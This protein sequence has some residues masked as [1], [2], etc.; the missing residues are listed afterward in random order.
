VSPFVSRHLEGKSVV[1]TGGGRG[2]GRAI[3]LGAADA[4]ARVVVADYGGAVDRNQSG[5]SEAADA[6]VAEI[7]AAGGEAVAS[8]ADVSTMD[9]GRE[10]VELA[11]DTFG[12][13]DAMVCSAGITVLKYLWDIEEQE[14][15]D[16]IAVH[17]KGHFSCAK[18]AA[19][20]MVP[21]R[22]GSLVFLSSGALNGMPNVTAY[23]TAKAGILGFTWS[24]ANALG[25]FGITTNCMVPSAATRMSDNI[26]GN[27]GKLTERFGD[28]MRSDLAGGTY[29][30]PANV[31][32]FAVYLMSDAARE[33]NGQIFRVQGY[34]VGRLGML[35]YFPVIT[36]LGPWDVDTLTARIPAELGPDLQPLPMPWPEPEWTD[37]IAFKN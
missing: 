9:G 16:V 3:A 13:L 35:R 10:I 7:T 6:V 22:S 37:D 5:T 24:T 20:V 18:A 29:R 31:A 33:V 4:G 23:A 25:R 30:D 14:W 27:A 36:N 1:V 11:V 19:R 28:N 34:E 12:Q 8:A 26:Y 32:P 2:I 17:L 15:D 21:Q